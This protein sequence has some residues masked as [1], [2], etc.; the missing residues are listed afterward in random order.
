MISII[1][2]AHNEEDNL[3]PLLNSL[4]L[5]GKK[6]G[7]D[8]EIIVVDDN[9]TDKTGEI[10]DN[11]TKINNVKAIHRK[12]GSNGM[13]HALREGT[14]HA[15]GDRVIWVMG[16]RSD[17]IHTIPDIAEK[18]GEYDMVVASRYMEGGSSGDLDAFKA[19]MSWGYTRVSRT[20]FGIPIHDI[21]NAFRGF[22][23]EVFDSIA[24]ESGDFAISPEFAIKAHRKGYKLGE[25]PTKY[26]NRQA[27]K[28]KFDMLK[29]GR[30]YISLFTPRFRKTD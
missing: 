29:M 30:R 26:R 28:A 6:N 22:K 16:D 4:I 14:R 15:N 3:I 24:L 1:I 19:L 7:A 17:D 18:L 23:K 2:P 20:I 13:G 21:T 25:V 5:M 9:S 12:K 8:Y 10:A 27:G 11:Y